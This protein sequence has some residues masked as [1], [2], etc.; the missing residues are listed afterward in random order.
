MPERL[1]FEAGDNTEWR[2][3]Q[4]E[5]GT[6]TTDYL[7]DTLLKPGEYAEIPLILTWNNS[8]DNIGEK[9]NTAEISKDRNDSNSPDVDSTPNNK[10]PKEDDI[11]DA[12]VILAVKTGK[13]VLYIGLVF[14]TLVLLGAGVA[15]IKKY[16]AE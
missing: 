9:I 13:A 16:V 3:T 11:D 8:K 14:T 5:N 15:G 6:L 1:R 4:K 12:P 2:W 7:K 10:I